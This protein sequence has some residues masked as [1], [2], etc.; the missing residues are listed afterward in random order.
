MRCDVFIKSKIRGNII[1]TGE[2]TSTDAGA[3][4]LAEAAKAATRARDNFIF[5]FGIIIRNRGREG[6]LVLGR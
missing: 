2:L 1:T 3:K 6:G 5:A 4:A